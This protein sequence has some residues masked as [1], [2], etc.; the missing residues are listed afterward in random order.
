MSRKL[1]I[2]LVPVLLIAAL[3]A[4]LMACNIDLSPPSQTISNGMPF[5]YQETGD[6]C[7]PAAIQMSGMFYHLYTPTQ[8]DL[9]ADMHGQS[10]GFGIG[11]VTLD[12]IAPAMALYGG[13]GDAV[14]DHSFFT[15]SNFLAR[16]ISAATQ[17]TPVIA[18]VN[19]GYHAGV[20]NG[21][22]WHKETDPATSATMYVWDQLY[23]HDPLTGP[24]QSFTAAAW[25]GYN[26]GSANPVCYQA[27]S[28]GAAQA[29]PQ[30]MSQYD[31]VMY[32]GDG[33]IDHGPKDY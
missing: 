21:G 8:A 32:G 17:P 23:F 19:Q 3:T 33:G 5:V 2:H 28:N 29:G 22:Q 24:N 1:S 31:V 4:W 30:V 27:L 15:D 25:A 12:Q 26:C 11:G 10:G 9:F 20:I 14:L 13:V 7:V 18:L 16:Q 6:Y